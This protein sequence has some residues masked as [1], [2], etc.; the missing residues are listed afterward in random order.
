[1]NIFGFTAEFDIEELCRAHLNFFEFRNRNEEKRRDL[2][3]KNE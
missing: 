1:M 2:K 3:R